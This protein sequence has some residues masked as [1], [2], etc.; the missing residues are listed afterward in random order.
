MPASEENE[1]KAFVVYS[2]T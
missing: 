1:L 2:C